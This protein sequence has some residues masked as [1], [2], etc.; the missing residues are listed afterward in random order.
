MDIA[1]YLKH[2][3][4]PGDLLHDFLHL[5]MITKKEKVTYYSDVTLPR[6]SFG[7]QIPKIPLYA[8]LNVK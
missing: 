2:I 8:F 1:K 7:Q 6:K 5:N 3:N 4:M